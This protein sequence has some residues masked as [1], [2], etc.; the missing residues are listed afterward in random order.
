MQMR[1]STLLRNLSK[2]LQWCH[3]GGGG[4][5]ILEVSVGALIWRARLLV[6]GNRG[7]GDVYRVGVALVSFCSVVGSTV[8]WVRWEE[9]LHNCLHNY[10]TLSLSLLL[11]SRRVCV[12]CTACVTKTVTAQQSK[13]PT[14]KLVKLSGSNATNINLYT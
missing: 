14:S 9:I 3:G 11:T 10:R 1:V 12:T 8:A 13:Q 6:C 5:E 2:A 7:G 4:A